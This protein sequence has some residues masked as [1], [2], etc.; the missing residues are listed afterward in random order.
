MSPS[1]PAIVV[2]TATDSALVAAITT[3]AAPVLEVLA[4]ADHDG[5]LAAADA[6]V[7]AGRPV[8]LAVVDD[9]LPDT[10]ASETLVA[11]RRRPQLAATSLVLVTDRPSL[12]ALDPALEAFAV[13]AM[14]TRPWDPD[15]LRTTLG[16]LIARH[17]IE[18]EAPDD[19]PLWAVA[20]EADRA[21]QA[22]RS[23]HDRPHLDPGT[24]GHFLLGDE[25]PTEE[26]EALLVTAVDRALGHPP[27]LVVEPGAVLV[28]EGE[29]VGGVY[30]VVDGVVALTHRAPHGDVLLHEATTGPVLGVLSL[31]QREPAFLSCRAVTRVRAI[32]LTLAQLD[33]ALDDPAVGSLFTRVLLRSLARRHRRADE[34]Q[35]EVDRLNRS[36]AAE[37]DE[38]AA[39]LAA[40]EAAQEQLVD[41]TRMATLGE[42]AAGIAH[43]L[44][45]PIAALSRAVDHVAADVVAV[46]GDDPAAVAAVTTALDAEPV[47]TAELRARRGELTEVLGDRRLADRLVRAGIVDP[48]A[49]R[50]LAGEGDAAIARVERLHQL[51]T[52]LRDQRSAGSRIAA[53]VRT[54]RVHARDDAGGDA[55][56]EPVDVAVSVDDSIQ[57]LS[58]RLH[59]VEVDRRYAPA[60]TVLAPPGEL[61]RLWTNLLANALDA[62][63][64]AEHRRIAV[65]VVASADGDEVVV[66]ITDSGAGIPAEHRH[67]IFEP[68]FTTK[69]GRVEFGLGLGLVLSRR[70]VE[71]LG[72]T[73][74]FE[75]EPGRT[76]FEVRVPVTQQGDPPT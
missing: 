6:A 8:P 16:R 36:L 56:L 43:E 54:M 5:A 34:L 76:T 15:V 1:T 45:N 30:L 18:S 3:W 74:G 65:E 68:R 13:H 69:S 73:I 47:G 20:V 31:T 70:V 12:P 59:D 28:E 37:R 7:A 57:L 19:D 48:A 58:H 39:A 23:A 33:V 55:P 10:D 42:L 52:A 61:E 46:L 25:M 66:R 67:R 11:L 63:E 53:L 17:L 50:R 41:A 51:G 72:G 27:R 38:L 75:S 64:G 29:H 9:D 62:L 60:P 26:L 49:A 32:P 44:N 22:L 40:L 21:R 4:V 71:S 35:L 14:F 2:A 24:A